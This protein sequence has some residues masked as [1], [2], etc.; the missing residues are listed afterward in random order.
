MSDSFT[1]TATC[2]NSYKAFIN[3]EEKTLPYT[4]TQTY[5]QQTI[6]V[7][8][9]GYGINS[10]NSDTVEQSFVVPAKHIDGYVGL[11][12]FSGSQYIGI[13]GDHWYLQSASRFVGFTVRAVLD[14]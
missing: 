12:F 8:G 13:W 4:I 1:I 6:V 3:G 11:G 10:Q 14:S 2:P 5:K 7:S 9:Y